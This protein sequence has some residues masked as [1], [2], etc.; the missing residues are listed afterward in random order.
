LWQH[1]C[2]LG[3]DASYKGV[4]SSPFIHMNQLGAFRHIIVRER[5]VGGESSFDSAQFFLVEYIAADNR[6][7]QIPPSS[8]HWLRPLRVESVYAR[9]FP[10]VGKRLGINWQGNDCGLGIVDELNG[11]KQTNEDLFR[12]G[13]PEITIRFDV[14]S[15]SWIL[16]SGFESEKLH[17]PTMEELA[18]YRAVGERLFEGFGRLRGG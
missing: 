17:L 8:L 9:A 1:L 5:A 3:T 4:D 7:I 14:N 10:V 6:L 18:C 11:L 13:S 2:S 16:T 15:Y 12:I